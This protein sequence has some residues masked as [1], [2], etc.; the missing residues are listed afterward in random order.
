VP[1]DAGPLEDIH[2]GER[3]RVTSPVAGQASRISRS[4][5]REGR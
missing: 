3:V 2:A 1:E 5:E 4:G